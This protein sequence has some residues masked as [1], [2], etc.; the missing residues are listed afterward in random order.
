[1]KSFTAWLSLFASSSTLICCAIPSLLVSLGMGASL[2]GF[3]S[4]FPQLIWLS[5]YKNYIFLFSGVLLFM[6]FYLI[7]A[8]RNEPCPIDPIQAKACM[9]GR[10]WSIRILVFSSAL[11][12]I[13]A[14]FAF[15]A[16]AL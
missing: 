3:I 15:I 5:T 8:S 14:F 9:N 16:P 1:M 6:S 7:Y 13:G 10:K 11:W 4:T 2:A 12:I